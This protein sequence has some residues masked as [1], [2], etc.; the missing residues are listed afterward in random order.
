MGTASVVA[1]G[2]E[3]DHSSLQSILGQ[4]SWKLYGTFTCRETLKLVRERHVSVVLAERNLPDGG[5]KT[6]LEGLAELPERPRLIV[7]SR[8]ADHQLWAEVLN[9]GGYDVLA[10]PF[11][12]DEVLRV[13]LSAWRSSKQERERL[14]A[15]RKRAK[16]V[17][18]AEQ[19][20][21]SAIAG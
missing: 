4:S 8:L 15:A 1:C 9:L 2:L 6:L 10:T 12:K 16:S 5:W 13:G 20:A 19:T 3:I 17:V 14:A 7:C 18:R 11:D 21:V